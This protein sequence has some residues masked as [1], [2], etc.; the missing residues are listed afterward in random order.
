M[1]QTTYVVVVGVD[2][3]PASDLALDEALSVA[4][5]KE[6]AH[7]HVVYVRPRPGLPS[8]HA[9]TPITADDA[10]ELELYVAQRVSAFQAQHGKAQYERLFNHLRSD[11]AGHQIAQLAADVEADLVVV[12][13][14]DRSGVPRFLLGS[15]AEG[16]ARL[17]PCAVLIVRPKAAPA[18]APSIKPP[19]PHCV[20][21]RRAT[22]CAELWCQDHGERHERYHRV[23]SR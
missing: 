12:G 22:N 1:N 6:H 19:C 17:A 10:R 18:P 23:E 2:Y 14:H 16:V 11:N 8:P 15:V 20:E 4:S 3:S 13:T 9:E 7:L 21:V 5:G